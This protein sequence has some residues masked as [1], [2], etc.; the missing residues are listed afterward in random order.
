MKKLV[1]IL[2]QLLICIVVSAQE[3][4]VTTTFSPTKHSSPSNNETGA[5]AAVTMDPYFTYVT[6]EVKPTKN[7][8]RMNFWT[9]E[10]CHVEMGGK[11]Y[12][13]LGVLVG[14]D[15]QDSSYGHNWGWDNVKK[16][17]TYNYTLVFAGRAP[18]G[19]TDFSLIDNG[20]GA[21]GYSFRGY[22]I[23]NPKVGK[24][25]VFNTRYEFEE[26]VKPY[27]IQN[28]DPICGLYEQ[29]GDEGLRLAVIKSN[30]N[31][32]GILYCDDKNHFSWWHPGDWKAMLESSATP[33]AFK[34]TWLMANKR[35]NNDCF[36]TFDGTGMSTFISGE[37]S[38][39]IKM[40]P[41]ANTSVAGNH[42]NDNASSQSAQNNI[43]TGTGWALMDNYVVTNY[44]VIEGA[45]S[46]AIK[47]VNGDYV[48]SH[49]ATVIA[50]DKF[51]DLAIL[52]L[53]NG[54]IN[55]ESIPYS[56]VTSTAEVGEEIFVLGYPM[57]STMG[58]EIKLTTGV[59]S[60]RTGFQGDVSIYQISA[61]IQPGN[62]GG[63]LFDSNGNV[64]GI[65]SAKHQGAENVGYAI[66]TSY[67]K[68]LMES[69]ITDNV[70]PKTNRY[71]SSNLSGKVKAAKSFVYYI[72]CSD[73]ED[74][75]LTDISANGKIYNNPKISKADAINPVLKSVEL[76]SNQTILSFQFTNGVG[77]EPVAWVTMDSKA[78][79][80]ANGQKYYLSNAEGIAIS[81]NKTY[82]A[83]ATQSLIYK[84][85]F[86]PIPQET[87]SIDFVE[88][89][90]SDWN[91]Y[92]IQLQ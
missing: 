18:E 52:K 73:K 83:N 6:I 76:R 86:P 9:G 13:L 68:N 80:T 37:E 49:S 23:N 40:F 36:V 84:L 11:T 41:N 16:N 66:K 8:K 50:S 62:S 81:P 31:S 27:I 87:K 59:V 67:L 10:N 26:E 2:L 57:T 64:I 7:L 88:S 56:V 19:V 5:L 89:S 35:A 70:F 45:K 22:T 74:G 44:H 29:I 71:S 60:S 43:W 39:F 42:S 54:I 61:P 55:S 72:V 85:I 33:G 77:H 48:N 91:L 90:D 20:N 79:I 51:N 47:G 63:P 25:N 24:Y 78:F 65:V 14:N 58:D 17:Q 46:I 32:Y 82:F 15:V 4:L 53:N 75:S 30:D 69:V 3:N 28:S 34:G 12:P 21:H 38:K 92:G 1:F